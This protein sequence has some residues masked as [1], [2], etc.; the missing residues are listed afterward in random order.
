MVNPAPGLIRYDSHWNTYGLILDVQGEEVIE[1]ESFGSVL[2]NYENVT[3]S[4]LLSEEDRILTVEEFYE[5]I[6]NKES[7]CPYK[8]YSAF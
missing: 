4:S 5:E 6:R 1:L 8:I 7:S 2:D 3:R